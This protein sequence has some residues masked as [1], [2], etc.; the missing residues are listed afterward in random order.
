MNMASADNRAVDMHRSNNNRRGGREAPPVPLLQVDGLT[1]HFKTPAGVVKATDDV[2][3]DLHDDE[4]LAI[5][6]ESGSG[7]SVTALSLMKLVPEPPGEYVAGRI[8]VDG[9]SVLEATDGELEH[10]RGEK[11]SMIFQNPRAALNPS[12]TILNQMCETIWRHDHAVSKKD[13]T[14]HAY[15][16]LR[17]VGVPAPADVARSYPHQISGGMCQRVGLALALACQPKVLIADEP[18]T[19]L[20][21]HVQ[22][23]ILLTL[24]RAHRDKRIPIILITHDFGVVKAMSTRIIVMYAGK[25]QEEG[26]AALVLS[27]PQHP[28]TKALIESVPRPDQDVARLYQIPGQPP[29][30]ANLPRGCSFQDR[31]PAVMSRCREESPS[32]LQT[33]VGSRARCHLFDKTESS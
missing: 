8:V 4:I 29:N 32:F 11:I 3:F 28:Y 19:Q 26:P 24:K 2:S 22:A 30:L 27:Q 21:A 20:D 1:T 31:C 14:D 9:S 7:K 13:A 33:P 6:G 23:K 17:A 5:V 15:A 18:T 16:G 12:L 25:I 10:I